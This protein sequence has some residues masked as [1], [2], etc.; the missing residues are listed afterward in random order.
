MCFDII[1]HV[2][3]SRLLGQ[4]LRDCV[5]CGRSPMSTI[6]KWLHIPACLSSCFSYEPTGSTQFF[7]SSSTCAKLQGTRW[8]VVSSCLWGDQAIQA[9]A[10]RGPPRIHNKPEVSPPQGG[11]QPSPQS[12]KVFKDTSLQPPS[13]DAVACN[14]DWPGVSSLLSSQRGVA[15]WRRVNPGCRMLHFQ[16][17]GFRSCGAAGAIFLVDTCTWRGTGKP[18]HLAA[19]MALPATVWQSGKIGWN[20]TQRY[21]STHTSIRAAGGG[22]RAGS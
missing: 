10:I 20:H 17:W 16:G 21:M 8:P 18:G 4:H 3:S 13:C 1:L 11:K 7:F 5:S 15:R 6:I 12:T 9:R 19:K 22:A 14:P 2:I